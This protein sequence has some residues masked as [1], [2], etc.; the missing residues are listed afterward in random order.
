[1]ASSASRPPKAY[2]QDYIAR[3]RYSNTLPPPPNPPKLLELPNTGLANGHYTAAGFATRLSREQPLNIEADA[4][5]GM[6]IDLVGMPG[7]FDGDESAIQPSSHPPPLHPHDRALL[8]P[9]ATLGKPTSLTSGVSFLRRTEYISSETGR[10]RIESTTSKGLVRSTNNAKKRRRSDISKDDPI[11]ILRSVVKGFDIA[12]PRDAYTGPDTQ[13]DIRGAAPTAAELDAW[14]NPQHP[15]RSGVKLVDSYPLLPDLEAFPDSG[16]YV[17][18]KFA[19][20]PVAVSDTYDNRLSVG[21]LRP[22]ELRPELAAANEAQRAAHEA[23]PSKPP[24]GPPLFDYEYFLPET[25]EAAR[26]V[27]RKLDVNDPEKDS[28]ALYTDA[29]KDSGEPIF[30]YNR[31]RAY[32]TA[33]QSGG[34]DKKYEELALALHDP[35]SVDGETDG[36]RKLQKAAYF[37]PVLQ[38]AQI[39]AR[40]A[41]K[42]GV[43]PGMMDEDLEADKVDCLDVVIREANESENA[44]RAEHKEECELGPDGGA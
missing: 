18:I 41:V 21:L 3:I 10:N 7:V 4:E 38:K 34:A 20:N 28:P 1:M 36:T 40:R 16:G 2:H 31:L 17:V 33:M 35:E 13:N 26:N 23:D 25:A 44:R 22:L 32:E 5:L 8:R 27:R 15:S 19:T 30:K 29:S 11:Y 12:Y 14:N 24:P 37:Y 6:P 43:A 39:R 9:L 42:V